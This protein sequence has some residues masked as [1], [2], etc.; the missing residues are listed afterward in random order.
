MGN[1]DLLQIYALVTFVTFVWP[2]FMS[3]FISGPKEF[4]RLS[5]DGKIFV[6]L[7]LSIFWPLVV[8]T[9]LAFYALTF[10]FFLTDF[11]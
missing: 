8:L 10:L 2:S 4:V 1:S 11:L 6:L 9:L 3:G 7:F 5:L